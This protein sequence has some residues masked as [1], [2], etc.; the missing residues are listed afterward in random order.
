[1]SWWVSL[2][3]KAV[4]GAAWWVRFER[5]RAERDKAKEQAK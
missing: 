3:P 1:M 4:K 2:V 5:W